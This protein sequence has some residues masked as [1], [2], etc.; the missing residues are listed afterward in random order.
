MTKYRDSC[1]PYTDEV[2]QTVQVKFD[3]LGLIVSQI[4]KAPMRTIAGPQVLDPVQGGV[5]GGEGAEARVVHGQRL[6]AGAVS[7]T[8]LG[9]HESS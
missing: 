8:S 2:C 5:Q 3:F 1:V 4:E 9:L 6:Q 7:I